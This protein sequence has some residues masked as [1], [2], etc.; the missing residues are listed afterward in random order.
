MGFPRRIMHVDMDAFYSAVEQADNTE[1]RGKPVIVGGST[2]GVVCAASYEARRYGVRSA[3]PIFQAKKLC[4][5]GVYLPV[6]M[7]R[8]REVSREVMGILGGISP[9][10]E[11]IS[12]DEA[13]IDITGTEAIHGPE[14]EL[15]KRVKSAIVERTSL[16]CSVGIA[17]NKFLAKIASDMNKPDG[18]TIIH[19]EDVPAF[20]QT[21][22][23]RKVPGI[24]E[25]TLGV[26]REF[27]VSVAS[28]VLRYPVSYWTRRLGKTG[29]K[30]Y[31]KARGIDRSPVVPY[32][33]P[34]SCSAEDTFPEDIDEPAEMDRWI[35]SQAETVGREL[36][37]D[38]FCGKTVT[39]KV[40]FSDFK[41]ITRS[42]TLP[43]PTS[44]TQTIFDTAVKL[45]RGI[46]LSKPVRLTGVG[47][48]NLSRGM[49]QGV[50][51]P[52]FAAAR[53]QKIDEALDA[54]HEKFGKESIRRGRMF[55]AR[56][57][58]R[59]DRSIP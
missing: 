6:R 26:F 2:R 12:V 37:K 23:L 50:L 35:L 30:L 5:E 28:D 40:K 14:D 18:L 29:V 58:H 46:N 1:L 13:T 9:L 15:A 11:I 49:T 54:I 44:S 43:K 38:G 41:V 22:P 21:L 53:Q 27:G 59:D 4:P 25:K 10:M 42:C 56:R 31:E 34:K 33:E 47:M 20:L 55:S 36:R 19:E 52:D 39:L 3:M 45:L 17:P 8:Y 57:G 32:S 24:G 48:A 7:H 16:T 51:F